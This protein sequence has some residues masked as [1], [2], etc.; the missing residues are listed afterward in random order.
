MS[1][2]GPYQWICLRAIKPRPQT[3]TL[4]TEYSPPEN[5]QDPNPT[6]DE[7][8]A[9][10]ADFK[11]YLQSQDTI[12]LSTTKHHLSAIRHTA[13]T[14]KSFAST[15]PSA[16]RIALL[17]QT[18]TPP[19]TTS[20]F[21]AASNNPTI[22]TATLLAE[23]AK[24]DNN[25]TDLENTPYPSET[26]SAAVRKAEKFKKKLSLWTKR[27]KEEE[28]ERLRAAEVSHRTRFMRSMEGLKPHVE[29]LNEV[30]RRRRRRRGGAAA[31]GDG[32]DEGGLE[33]VARK[34]QTVGLGS[35]ATEI[36]DERE[37]GGRV[38]NPFVGGVKQKEKKAVTDTVKTKQRK[39]ATDTVNTSKD[40]TQAKETAPTTA[41]DAVEVPKPKKKMT[42]AE[43][44]ASLSKQVSNSD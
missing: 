36:E 12:H 9:K 1:R 43:M 38:P 26:D 28:L 41:A 30:G 23:I 34:V 27:E 20:P 11:S 33:G 44:Q 5:T 16:S 37:E 25:L 39:T 15:L 2:N 3:R 13:Q 4:S 32:Q 40:T 21:R 10:T 22:P 29:A 24:L 8:T 42:L 7:P 17:Q 14:I 31:G 18:G 19:Y 35:G 6:P